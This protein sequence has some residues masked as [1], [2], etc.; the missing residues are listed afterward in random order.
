MAR[1]LSNQLKAMLV[2]EDVSE[3]GVSVWQGNCFTVQHFAY[4]CC[5]DRNVGGIPYGATLPFFLDFTVR[6]SS[7]NNGKLFFKRM[8]LDE[9]FPYSFLFNAV[10]GENGRLGDSEDAM[11]ATG[12]LTEVEE[13]YAAS[14]KE[15]G[16]DEQMLIQAR[17]LVSKLSYLGREKILNLTITND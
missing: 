17:L 11:V 15:D 6:V 7:G 14:S 3:Q 16:S 4:E 12:Y 5:R 9:T 13:R 1:V 10:F 2:M 8:G